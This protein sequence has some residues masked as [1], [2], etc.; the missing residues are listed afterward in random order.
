[1]T[2]CPLNNLARNSKALAFI[3]HSTERKNRVEIVHF[4]LSMLSFEVY[5]EQ[6]RRVK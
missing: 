6:M 4:V 1:M 5:S 2:Q 3:L